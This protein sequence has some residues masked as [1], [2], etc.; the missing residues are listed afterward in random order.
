[1][2][3]I[4]WIVALVVVAFAA[5]AIYF[6]A[7]EP[8]AC[9]IVNKRVQSRAVLLFD[10][11]AGPA[12]AREAKQGIAAVQRCLDTSQMSVDLYMTVAANDRLLGRF[13]HAADMYSEALKYDRRP[14]LYLNLGI[15]QLQA[16]QRE[17]G[18]VSLT[19][20]CRFDINLA[21][22]IPDPAIAD[23][24]VKRVNGERQKGIEERRQR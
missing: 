2:T 1:M 4:R 19:Q 9:D 17:A 6:M 11:P 21:N 8:C 22:A 23:I 15:M 3:A 10:L 7:Y 18:I 5:Y 20:A 24:V 16:N 12:V 14:E 13:Q